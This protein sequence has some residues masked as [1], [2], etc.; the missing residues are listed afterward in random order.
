M[1]NENRSKTGS[2]KQQHRDENFV[3][4]YPFKLQNLAKGKHINFQVS[5]LSLY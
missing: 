1:N 5:V 2:W 4:N 3:V